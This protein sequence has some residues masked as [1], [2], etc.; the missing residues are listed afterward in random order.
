MWNKNLLRKLAC[1]MMRMMLHENIGMIVLD[2]LSCDKS[3][4]YM[5]M[6]HIWIVLGCVLFT[7]SS[8][9]SN[10]DSFGLCFVHF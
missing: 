5:H 3:E 2:F 7:F 9:V 6:C 10:L 4:L 1:R 8:H